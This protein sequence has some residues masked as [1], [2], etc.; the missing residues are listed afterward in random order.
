MRRRSLRATNSADARRGRSRSEQ[1]PASHREAARDAPPGR[2]QQGPQARVGVAGHPAQSDQLL[3]VRL[4]LGGGEARGALE[5]G[6]EH[7]SAARKDL[8]DAL[9]G[10][11]RLGTGDPG[12]DASPGL[13]VFAPDERDRGAADRPVSRAPEPSPDQ[14]PGQ[15]ELIEP[16]AL[17]AAHARG[18]DRPLPGPGGRLEA[19]ELADDLG[20]AERAREPVLFG[21]MLPARQESHE[22]RRRD[23]R[24]L[25]AQAV[26]RV[27]VDAGEEPPVAPG[28]VAGDARPHGHAFGLEREQQRRQLVAG[29]LDRSERLEPS[30]QDGLRI[31]GGFRGEPAPVLVDDAPGGGERRPDARASPLFRRLA[32]SSSVT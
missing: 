24:D 12:A 22:L 11:G 13:E 21:R 8:P 30:P 19:G 15:R 6:K 9:R 31:P 16:L 26:Q 23:G 14:L 7:R 4:E 18:K 1:A 10:A 3:E 25:A 17:V 27:A 5:L 20:D 2:N 32:A 28:R 29:A